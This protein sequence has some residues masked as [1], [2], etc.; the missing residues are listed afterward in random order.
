[1][2]RR[3]VL[4]LAAAGAAAWVGV[5]AL[6]AGKWPAVAVYKNPQCGCCGAWVDHLRAAGFTV[7]VHETADTGPVRKRQG[8]PDAFASCHTAV[9]AGYALEGHVPAADVKRLLAT[10]PTAAGLA[11]PGMPAGS[12]GMEVPNQRDPYEVLLIDKAGRS[13]VFANYPRS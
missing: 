13:S 1:M 7:N 5:P 12:P 3:M 10:R 9:V 11:V 4:S 2:K 6:A 8:I